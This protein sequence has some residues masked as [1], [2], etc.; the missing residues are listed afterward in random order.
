MIL[1]L[2]IPTR[3]SISFLGKCLDSVFSQDTSDIEVIVVDNGSSD[4]TFD[5][6][7]ANYPQVILIANSEN[8]G[9]AAAR[10]QGIR[11]SS[12]EYIGFLDSDSY[13]ESNFFE[14]LKDSVKTISDDAAGISP[15]II[16]EDSRAIFSCGLSISSIY[17]VHDIG[18]R[19]NQEQFMQRLEV[20]GLNTCCAIVKREAL[21]SIEKNNQYF[22]EDFFFLFEDADL[23]LRLKDRG[24]KFL[25]MPQFI[26]YHQGGGSNIPDDYRRFLCFRNRWYMILKREKGAR[27]FRLFLKSFVYDFVRTVHFSFTNKYCLTALRDIRKKMKQ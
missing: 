24:W 5:F 18:K 15:K 9:A 22:D 25:C 26:C 6:V 7:G 17:R 3:N 1:S 4:A 11:A 14:R 27:C 20:G 8:K 19:Q 16:T 2:V 12:G 10:N 21:E 23:S 13:L